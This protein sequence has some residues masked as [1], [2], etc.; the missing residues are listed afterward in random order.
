MDDAVLVIEAAYQVSDRCV[1]LAQILQIQLIA[2]GGI[3]R[4]DHQK[5]AVFGN[6]APN[7]TAGLLFAAK[8]QYVFRLRGAQFMIVQFMVLGFARQLRTFGRLVVAAVIKAFVPFPADAAEFDVD[9]RV[10]D[11]R[12]GFGIEHNHFTPV[13][14]AFADLVGTQTAVFGEVDARQRG[15]AIGRKGVGIEENLGFAAFFL[16][17]N[18][19]LVLQAVVFVEV[20]VSAFYKGC[21]V[22]FI[23]PKAFETGFDGVTEGDFVEVAKAH[24]VLGYYPG[25]GFFRHIV[26]EPAVRV[27]DQGAEIFV[28]LVHF[29]GFWVHECFFFGFLIAG[30]E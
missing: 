5:L 26:F 24:L 10:F 20:G 30:G 28:N 11:H 13:A 21:A 9:E 7:V 1:G 12:L 23:V 2:V 8:Y 6:V 18:D 14:T 27:I 15:G 3:G 22:F 16:A 25:F 29:F 4:C 17:I 19:V